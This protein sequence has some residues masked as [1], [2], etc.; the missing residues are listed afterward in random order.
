MT[1]CRVWY[2]K[3][4]KVSISQAV[5][6]EF[7]REQYSR[8]IISWIIPPLPEYKWIR[9][10]FNKIPKQAPQFAGL[11]YEDM[12]TSELPQMNR[13]NRDRLRGTKALGLYFIVDK[14][15]LE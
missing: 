10:M 14:K 8:K 7:Y 1:M 9:K 12:D 6:Y 5:G 13:E 3:D 2:R 15:T 4:R 11:D